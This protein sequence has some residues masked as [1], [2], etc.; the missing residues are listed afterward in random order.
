MQQIA[1]EACANAF[2]ESADRIKISEDKK[3]LK[4]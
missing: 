4:N 2:S 3:T 1:L